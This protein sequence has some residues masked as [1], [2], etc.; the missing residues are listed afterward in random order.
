MAAPWYR[1]AWD[2]GAGGVAAAPDFKEKHPASS[3]EYSARN[4]AGP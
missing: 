3:E 2:H 4:F 1:S